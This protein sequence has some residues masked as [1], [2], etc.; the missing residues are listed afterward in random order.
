MQEMVRIVPRGSCPNCGHHQFIVDEFQRNVYLTN[1]DGEII[2]CEEKTYVAVGFCNCCGKVYEMMPAGDSFIP[3]TPL[4][5][6]LYEYTPHYTP[7][8]EAKDS[9]PNPMEKR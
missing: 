1:R 7:E 3:M 6:L 4:R 8:R 2:D 5:K 9:L